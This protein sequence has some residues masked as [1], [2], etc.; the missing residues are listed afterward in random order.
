MLLGA[1]RGLAE[2]GLREEVRRASAPVI[3][4]FA[5]SPESWRE[6]WDGRV[7]EKG[8][9]RVEAI[10]HEV[11]RPDVTGISEDTKFHFLWWSVTRL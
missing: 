8:T 5:H 9:V 1:H 11:K 4:L 7:F 2:A 6:L 3:K 10:L